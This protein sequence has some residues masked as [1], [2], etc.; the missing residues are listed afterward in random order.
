MPSAGNQAYPNHAF[1][2]HHQNI[3]GKFCMLTLD[4]FDFNNDEWDSSE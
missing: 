1:P 4:D 3:R 2:A